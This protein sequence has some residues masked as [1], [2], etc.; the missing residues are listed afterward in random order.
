MW[1][2]GGVGGGSCESWVLGRRSQQEWVWVATRAGMAAKWS[3][4]GWGGDA[5][6]GGERLL[7]L[8]CQ[9]LRPLRVRVRHTEQ[10]GAGDSN[11]IVH[12]RRVLGIRTCGPA[13]SDARPAHRD[14]VQDG[15]RHNVRTR[16]GSE[17]IVDGSERI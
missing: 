5:G 6:R 2:V 9:S 1:E 10:V 15:V 12:V 4:N 13:R 11:R 3:R 17:G 14:T 16:A 7:R 8:V